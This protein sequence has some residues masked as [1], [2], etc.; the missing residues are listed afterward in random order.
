MVV[1]HLVSSVLAIILFTFLLGLVYPLAV[2]GIAQ[3]L[4]PS[5]ANGSLV[6]RQGVVVGSEL[7]G[8]QFTS[9]KYFWSRP[10][11]TS[12]YPYNA[13]ASTGSNAGPLNPSVTDEVKGRL[14]DLKKADSANTLPVPV[15]LVTSSG[16]GLDPHISVAAANY[17]VSRVAHAR[18]ID[19]SRVREIVARC[20]EGRTLGILGES[21]VNVLEANL[22]LDEITQHAEV[23]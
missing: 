17:Q 14:S 20:T 13:A 3:I 6:T 4:F 16:S 15:D 22:A 2:T 18:G 11:P 10:S 5:K 23:R 8:Q 9:P 7:I 12:P 21:R 19:E 1:K